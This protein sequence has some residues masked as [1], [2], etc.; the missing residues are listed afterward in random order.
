MLGSL[1]TDKQL[2]PAINL[3][4]FHRIKL[5]REKHF[6]LTKLAEFTINT[7]HHRGLVREKSL[8]CLLFIC[9]RNVCMLFHF[10]ALLGWHN[11]YSLLRTG[12]MLSPKYQQI[13]PHHQTQMQLV[14]SNQS[15]RVS[16]PISGIV[17][18]ILT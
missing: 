13:A 3:K 18:I 15:L 17:A 8:L 1:G 6:R 7:K 14:N 4:F 5:T 12:L 9:I 10:T 11:T 2:L 16:V